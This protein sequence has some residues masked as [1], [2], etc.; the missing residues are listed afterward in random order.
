MS[1]PKLNYKF[2]FSGGDVHDFNISPSSLPV[3][4]HILS[5]AGDCPAGIEH[6]S[7]FAGD[8]CTVVVEVPKPSVVENILAATT[9]LRPILHYSWRDNDE[10]GVNVNT[11]D[12]AQAGLT[13][14]VTV[15]RNWLPADFAIVATDFELANDTPSAS[16]QI[17]AGFSA[18]AAENNFRYPLLVSAK[19][20]TAGDLNQQ[21]NSCQIAAAAALPQECQLTVTLAKDAADGDYSYLVTVRDSSPKP[22]NYQK[23]LTIQKRSAKMVSVT[24]VSQWQTVMGSGYNF[25]V[26]LLAGASL[27]DA[28]VVSGVNGSVNNKLLGSANCDMAIYG[29]A[30]CPFVVDD[31]HNYSAWDTLNTPTSSDPDHPRIIREDLGIRLSVTSTGTDSQINGSSLASNTFTLTGEI[32]AP[33]VYLP[34]TGQVTSYAP[35]DDASIRTGITIDFPQ[36]FVPDASGECLTDTLTGLMWRKTA[37]MADFGNSNISVALNFAAAGN[38]CGHTDWRMANINELASLINYESKNPRDWLKTQG[39]HFGYNAFL[40]SSTFFAAENGSRK[41]WFVTSDGSFNADEILGGGH[42]FLLVRGGG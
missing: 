14:Q 29:T 1:S 23:T 37:K 4:A 39:F 26:R 34:Q 42:E 41:I 8:S 16:A 38:W 33:Y 40:V 24:P 20:L 9:T 7:Y 2:S 15:A 31:Y 32:V 6:A 35:A 36:R 3:G 12:T 19:I 13:P 21:K 5:N 11:S 10:G 28:P 25:A 18:P 27:T 17:T 22:R 30:G